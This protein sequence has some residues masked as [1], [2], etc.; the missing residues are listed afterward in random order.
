[1]YTR[2]LVSAV[3]V[4]IEKAID[5]IRSFEYLFAKRVS[6]AQIDSRNIRGLI[7]TSENSTV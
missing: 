4:G 2:R 7:K 5:T 1:M 3:A 6:L